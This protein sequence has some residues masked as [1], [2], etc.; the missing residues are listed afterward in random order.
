M[1]KPYSLCF[2]LYQIFVLDS[3]IEILFVLQIAYDC[4][5]KPII[6][7]SSKMNFEFRFSGV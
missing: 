3:V 5:T 7:P 4:C 6:T 1:T 2:T